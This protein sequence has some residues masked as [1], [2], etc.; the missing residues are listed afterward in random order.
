MVSVVIRLPLA[1][2]I[3]WLTTTAELPH[4]RN[5][6]VFVSLLGAWLMGA[7]ITTFFYRRGKWKSSA[8]RG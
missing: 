8:L 5:E 6:C 7:L 3:S 4:G 2:G 1:Y